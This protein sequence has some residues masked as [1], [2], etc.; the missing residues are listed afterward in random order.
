[1]ILINPSYFAGNTNPGQYIYYGDGTNWGIH[2]DG[3]EYAASLWVIVSRIVIPGS[4][5]RT[6]Q[7]SINYGVLSS[8]NY[9]SW[10]LPG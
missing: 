4:Y 2:P 9:Y 7:I 3:I 10:S 1:M 6:L 8:R 5:C